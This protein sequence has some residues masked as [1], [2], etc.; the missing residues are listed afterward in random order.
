L[1]GAEAD[2]VPR[3]E[4]YVKDFLPWSLG[5]I[6]L[7]KSRGKLVLRATEIP[8]NKSPTCGISR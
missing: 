1:I 4:S 8:A 2:R 3:N 7:G 5:I 6:A